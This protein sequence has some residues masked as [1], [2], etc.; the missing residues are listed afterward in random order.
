MPRTTTRRRSAGLHSA[1]PRGSAGDPL[2]RQANA[3]GWTAWL[4]QARVAGALDGRDDEVRHALRAVELRGDV[5]HLERLRDE[6]HRGAAARLNAQLGAVGLPPVAGASDANLRLLVVLGRVLERSSARAP[7]SD[8]IDATLLSDGRT[9]SW[10]KAAHKLNYP[11]PAVVDGDAL[12]MAARRAADGRGA[13]LELARL[14]RGAVVV[15]RR[16]RS[17]RVA[18]VAAIDALWRGGSP[19]PG[20]AGRRAAPRLRGQRTRT[21]PNRPERRSVARAR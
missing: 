11:C 2:A 3:A 7:T 13:S 16:G 15:G 5:S 12:R 1:D 17:P 6:L 21:D 9:T 18:D 20:G 8:S 19:A 10:F 4:D 14:W